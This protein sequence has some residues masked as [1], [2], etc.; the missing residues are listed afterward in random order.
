MV[1]T[2]KRAREAIWWGSRDRLAHERIATSA[3]TTLA[4]MTSAD[5]VVMID[6]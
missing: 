4:C 3:S 1:T 2:M 6:A 5:A